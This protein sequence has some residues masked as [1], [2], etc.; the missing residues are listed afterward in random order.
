MSRWFDR[1]TTMGEWGGQVELQALGNALHVHIPLF[2]V[3]GG[4][5]YEEVVGG[6]GVG[7]AANIL[8][9]TLLYQGQPPHYDLAYRAHE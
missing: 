2:S 1:V 8:S 9:A 3:A 4:D 7:A 5:S 6:G